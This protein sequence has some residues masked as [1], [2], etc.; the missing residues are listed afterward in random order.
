MTQV[1]PNAEVITSLTDEQKLVVH[2]DLTSPAKVIAVAGAG[3]TTTLI[4]RI[5]HLLAQGVDPSHIGVFMFNKSAQEEFSERLSKRLLG[6]GH[7]RSPS[8]MTFHAFGMKFCRRLEQ[9]GWLSAA[10]LVTDDFSLVKMLREALQRLVRHGE[11]IAILDEKDWLE[12]VLLFVDQVKASDQSAQI[13][14]EAL[15]WSNERK[16]FP[17]LYDELEKLRKRNNMRF[18]ADLLSDPYG[19][20]NELD[21]PERVRVRG[22]VPDFRYLLIDEFQDINPCQYELLKRLYPAPCQWMIVGDVQQCIYEWR[23]ASPDIM[24]S[25]F[26]Q[27]F[28]H[29]AT[30]PLSTSFRFGHAVGLMASSVIS[31][32][33]PDALVIGAGE[34]TRVS[35][36]RAPK[37]GKALL[38]ELKSWLEDGHALNDTAVLVRLYSDMVPVQLALMHKGVPYQLH[39]DSP[40]LE[41]RQI[42]MLMAYLAVI[43]GGLENAS[44]FFH[45]DDIEY[46]LMIPSLGGSLAQRKTLIQQ[47]KQSP[48][49]LPQIIESVADA[50]DGWRAK[51]L[52]ERAD[53]LRS[54]SIYR[55]DP[56]QGLAHTLEKLGIYRYFEST[57]SKDIQTQ[58][59]I[60]TCD[61]FMAYVRGVGGDAQ[62]ILE[63]LATLNEKQTD[64]VHG[65][66]LMTIHKSKGLE[67]DQVLL[68]GLQEGRFPYYDE[69][70]STIDKQAASDLASERRLFYVAITRAKQKLVLLETPSTDEH[71]RMKQGDIPRAALKSLSLSRFVFEAQPYAVSRICEAWYLDN[72]GTP[73]DTEKGLVFQRYLNAV[74]PSPSLT[75]RHRVEGTSLLQPGDKVR[76]DQFGQGVVVRQ[77]QDAKQMIFVDFGE[78]GLKRFNP[79]HTQLIK[80]S[81]RA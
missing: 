62:S 3:K 10:K 58:E 32:N 46:L 75:F 37:T 16:F 45:P 23:G 61:A 2:H 66:H 19:L 79:K 52:Y 30:Y 73:I 31:E 42:R 15:G 81:S 27:D 24:A 48:H 60:A 49:L 28:E 69:D 44:T 35:F 74:D 78:V 65:V 26:D 6:A 36:A 80:V 11:K 29:V 63:Q 72:V 4:S 34:R 1:Q 8:V 50:T 18:F 53:W 76:H 68:S 64:D 22:L 21:E 54:L 17:A 71:K 51:K 41:N 56:A 33:D 47:A 57:S 20:I 77:E 39:G 9:Q 5:E 59:K 40:L 55:T 14:F 13:V 70:L 7:F 25:Q 38:G 43:A 67:F 12:D